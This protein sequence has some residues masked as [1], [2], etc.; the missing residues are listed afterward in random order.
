MAIVERWLLWG[1][2][3]KEDLSEWMAQ[4]LGQDHV[5]I[6]RREVVIIAVVI[7]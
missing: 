6:V 7:L 3:K 2:F 1:G 4:K 5:A